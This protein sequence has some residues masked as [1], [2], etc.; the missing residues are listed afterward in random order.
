MEER[1]QPPKGEVSNLLF[2]VIFCRKIKKKLLDWVGGGVGLS[3]PLDPPTK[4][5]D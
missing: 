1:R 4:L 5:S 2:G 3:H